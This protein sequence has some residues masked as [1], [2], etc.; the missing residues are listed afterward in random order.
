[1]G[2]TPKTQVIDGHKWTVGPFP[3]RRAIQ[4]KVRLAKMAGPAIGELLPTLGSLA[5]VGKPCD[6]DDKTT[7]EQIDAALLA[8]PRAFDRLAQNLSETEF[9]QTILDLMKLSS[10]DDNAITE[11]YFDIE[12][13]GNFGEMYKALGFILKVNYADFLG[14]LGAS[15]IGR[16]LKALLPETPEKPKQS[17]ET[18]K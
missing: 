7:E 8:V 9:T 10:R 17:S 11:E 5:P 14:G 18:S 12:F 6:D 13:A 3:A 2:L 16:S 15:G 1:M 4:L